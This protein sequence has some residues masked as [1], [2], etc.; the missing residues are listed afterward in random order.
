[1]LHVKTTHY[2]NTTLDDYKKEYEKLA[3]ELD[4]LSD[5]YNDLNNLI[6]EEIY[7]SPSEY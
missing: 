5:F 1:M 6:D 4:N 7:M 3:K 2:E